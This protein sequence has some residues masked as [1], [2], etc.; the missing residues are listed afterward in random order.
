MYVLHIA[1]I[2]PKWYT[3]AQKFSA[4]LTIRLRCAVS[5]V[6]K[7]EQ[8]KNYL[9]KS[10]PDSVKYSSGEFDQCKQP[11]RDSSLELCFFFLEMID[12]K[13]SNI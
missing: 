1:E 9:K 3:I 4:H 6:V 11:Q 7:I 10:I 2:Q 13:I 5:S 8:R 12:L